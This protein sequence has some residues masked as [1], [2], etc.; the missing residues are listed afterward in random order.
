MSI[1]LS[2]LRTDK[3]KELN[4]AWVPFESGVELLI[5]RLNNYR[6][7]AAMYAS[8]QAAGIAKSKPEVEDVLVNQKFNDARDKVIS[9]TILLGWRGPVR[10]GGMSKDD[11]EPAFLDDDGKPIEYSVENSRRLISECPDLRTFILVA[12]SG[13]EHFRHEQVEAT[14]GNSVPAS[15]GT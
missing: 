2:S 8:M 3:S 5:A 15:A 12:S 4:G 6:Y 1:K 10:P 14:K 11:R 7:N 13:R 9:E